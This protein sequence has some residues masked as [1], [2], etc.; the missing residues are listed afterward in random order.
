MNN[1]GVIHYANE[2]EEFDLTKTA[3]VKVTYKPTG[4]V[5]TATVKPGEW[6]LVK[7]EE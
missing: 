5:Y 4:K 6:K 1:K 2:P 3:E 7:I